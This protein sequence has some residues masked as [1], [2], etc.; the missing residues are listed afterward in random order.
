MRIHKKI[1]QI[2]AA[3]TIIV[4]GHSFLYAAVTQPAQPLTGFGGKTYPHG[5]V[6]KRVY[7]TG[8][9][10]YWIYEP[11]D[12]TPASAP[13]IVFNHGW[14]GTNPRVYGA[15]IEHIVRRG[16]FVIFPMYQEPGK[17]RHP[18]GK[19]TSNA[20]AAVKDAITQ[21]KKNS[22]GGG[23][24]IPDLEKFAVV[25]HSAGGQITA[26][27]AALA[28]SSGL[29]QPKAIMPVQ[30][31]KSQSRLKRS[32]ISLEDLSKIPSTTLILTVVGDKDRMAGDIDAKR[33]FTESTQIP[34]ENKDFITLTSDDHGQP[35]LKANHF[36]PVAPNLDYDSG[37]ESPRRLQLKEGG[38][39]GKLLRKRIAQRSAQTQQNSDGEDEY[40][41]LEADKKIDALDYNGLWKL[42]DALCDAAFYDRNRE[43]ALGGTTEQK[44]MGNWSDGIPVK[45]L[46]S[47]DSPGSN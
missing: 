5:T 20:V 35:E 21:L 14:G 6:A 37:I 36:A 3:L 22:Q 43:Y 29:P 18:P 47:T 27:M 7:R 41:D 15:W 2:I 40:P 39:I 24:P 1:I 9:E 11:A 33:I 45:P 16:N 30:P 17:W 12:P 46:D 31:G 19:V 42:F 25:G 10:Q 13:V 38:I 8:P 26:N 28:A 32:L 34:F 4:S 23:H 44:F